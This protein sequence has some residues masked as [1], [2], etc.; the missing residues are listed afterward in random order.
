ML[1]IPFF[2]FVEA[3]VGTITGSLAKIVLHTFVTST[4]LFFFSR[5]LQGFPGGVLD[6]DVLH[7]IWGGSQNRAVWWPWP[8]E[9]S[10]TCYADQ[11]VWA[12]NRVGFH[13]TLLWV[14][15]RGS[16]GSRCHRRPLWCVDACCVLD[17]APPPAIRCLSVNGSSRYVT[18]F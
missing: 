3:V 7:R 18:S 13:V 11:E 9:R 15:P 1:K 17:A 5:L 6:F 8:S 4:G 14:L 10:G 2:I 12:G 16:P